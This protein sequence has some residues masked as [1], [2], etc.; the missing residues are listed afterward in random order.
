MLYITSKQWWKG[1]TDH[2]TKKVVTFIEDNI[3]VFRE[4]TIHYE[5]DFDE[6][7]LKE[8]LKSDIPLEGYIFEPYRLKDTDGC[9][10]DEYLYCQECV[11]NFSDSIEKHIE[12][13]HYEELLR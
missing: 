4:E 3:N 13:N 2:Q 11:G 5:F 9:I 1:L 10:K 6:I 8:F 12:E 7:A